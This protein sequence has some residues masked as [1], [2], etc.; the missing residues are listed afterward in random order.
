MPYLH[1]DQINNTSDSD[2]DV[3]YT[4][5]HVVKCIEFTAVKSEVKMI[6]IHMDITGIDL[7][8]LNAGM[9]CARVRL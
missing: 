8:Y 7:F 1:F 2:S 9:V 5:M 4:L 3:E 6:F